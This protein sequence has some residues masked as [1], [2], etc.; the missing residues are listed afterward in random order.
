MGYLLVLGKMKQNNY[1]VTV[2]NLDLIEKLKKVGVSTF[3][4]P[5]KDYTV[6][7]PNTYEITDIKEDNAYIFINRILP[8][9]D[10]DDLRKILNN[11]PNNIKGIMFDDL[12]VLELI[13]ELA[14]EKILYLNHFSTNYESINSFLEYVDSLVISTDITKEEIEV[15]LNK[16]NKPLIIYG[17][18]YV[19]VM[20]S[21]R[22]L[23]TNF[24]KHFNLENKN[25][26]NIKD[27]M[28]NN[29]F[30][31]YENNFGTVLYHHLP[32]NSLEIKHD[33]I[34]Y[35]LINT[36]FLKDEEVLNL[37]NSISNDSEIN[38][39]YDRGFLDKETIYK[40]KDGD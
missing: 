19:P 37:F 21:R 34:Y 14:I 16:T 3:L 25:I 33:N 36:A 23:L 22:M 1:L 15:I 31:A 2:N 20:Y 27:K 7:F 32:S 13:K 4:F 24:N 6:G 10:I 40:L 35:Y 29:K 30:F 5:L 17:F 12:G 18:G 8:S 9:D 11:L 38:I 26:S 28:A 39:P